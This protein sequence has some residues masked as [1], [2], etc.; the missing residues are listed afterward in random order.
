[1]AEYLLIFVGS[2]MDAPECPKFRQIRI[3]F[4]FGLDKNFEFRIEYHS[5]E[6]YRLGEL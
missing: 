2:W 6:L 1:M 5:F 3:E 4:D